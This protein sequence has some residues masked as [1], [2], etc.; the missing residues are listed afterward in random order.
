MRNIDL[1]R[2]CLIGSAI[3]DARGYAIEFMREG[4]IFTSVN[5]N[6]DSDSTGAVTGNILGACLGYNAIPEKFKTNLELHDV[7]LEIAD[8]LYNDCKISEYNE[9]KDEIWESKYVS[10][11]YMR[12]NYTDR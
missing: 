5:H 12:P 8:D 9:V 4:S 6:G 7:I 11:T 3:G 2:G 1:F 10:A